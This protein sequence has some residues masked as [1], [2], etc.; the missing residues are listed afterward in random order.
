M[1]RRHRRLG[2]RAQHRRVRRASR[3][4]LRPGPHPSSSPAELSLMLSLREYRHSADRLA[5]HL[6]WAALVAE[7][8]VLNTDGSFQGPLSLRGP[9]HESATE[10]HLNAPVPRA[11][12][13]N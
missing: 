11:H 1:D 9:A 10:P 12:T 8:V 13:K 2:G 4:R 7:G 3:F 6:P 5:D